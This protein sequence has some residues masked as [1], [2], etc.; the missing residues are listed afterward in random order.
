M[1]TDTE[2]KATRCPYHSRRTAT[3]V[4][5]DGSARCEECTEEPRAIRYESATTDWTCPSCLE[6]IRAGER[7]AVLDTVPETTVCGECVEW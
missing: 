7:T 2:T 4:R 1:T 6:L 5:A 3:T